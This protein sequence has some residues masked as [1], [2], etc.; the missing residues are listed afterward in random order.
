MKKIIMIFCLTLL[1]SCASSV[2]T[3]VLMAQKPLES[4]E[5]VAFFDI[6]QPY[7]AVYQYIGIVK[8]GDNGLASNCNFEMV[9]ALAKEEARKMGGN[10]IRLIKHDLPT[11]FGSSCHR[12]EAQVLKIE[13]KN[14][15]Q[16]SKEKPAVTT[17]NETVNATSQAAANPAPPVIKPLSKP[18]VMEEKITINANYGPAFRVGQLPANLNQVA[19]N[20]INALK[21]GSSFDISAFYNINQNTAVGIKYNSFDTKVTT[22]NFPVAFDDGT[23]GVAAMASDHNISFIGVV[24]AIDNK[25]L[26]SAFEASLEMAIGQ[27]RLDQTETILGQTVK[28]SGSTL[29]V[30]AGLGYKYRILKNIAIG[31]QLNMIGGVIREL[32]MQFPDGSTRTITA[33]DNEGEN[34]WRIDI[35]FGISFRL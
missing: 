13:A 2:S 14:T 10:A 23:T 12:I 25:S 26:N 35:N 32:K 11:T 7:P 28:T 5:A 1:A 17:V 9:I 22:N 34:V 20:H 30:T 19:K 27:I 18:Q 33:K 8:I 21:S 3:T 16:I 29:G 4:N 6:E 31:P 15:D 24:Y